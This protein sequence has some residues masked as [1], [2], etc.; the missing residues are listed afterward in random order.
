[1]QAKVEQD[2]EKEA[3]LKAEQEPTEENLVML[4]PPSVSFVQLN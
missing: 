2:A 4:R 3:E 1:M